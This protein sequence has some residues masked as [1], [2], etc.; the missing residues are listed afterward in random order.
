MSRLSL[1]NV[2]AMTS[3]S[4]FATLRT[5]PGRPPTITHE[6]RHCSDCGTR[7]ARLHEGTLCYRCEDAQTA[8]EVD[9]EIRLARLALDLADTEAARIDA[10]ERAVEPTYRHGCCEW[11]PLVLAFLDAPDPAIE[12]IG[13][14][15]NGAR[16]A[17]AE[18]IKRMRLEG[19]CYAVRRGERCYLIKTR[20]EGKGESYQ[21]SP[22]GPLLR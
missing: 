11:R 9:E 5:R 21:Q 15:A 6:A 13:C 20:K 16:T 2:P 22:G 10:V 12:V 18:C 4:G 19:E 14:T 3:V 8:R 17:L 1:P 7:I